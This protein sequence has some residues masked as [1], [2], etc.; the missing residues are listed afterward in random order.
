MEHYTTIAVAPAGTT[1]Q[2]LANETVFKTKPVMREFV[3]VKKVA[4]FS[5]ELVI[6]IVGDFENTVFDTES[7]TEVLAG[8][9]T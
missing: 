8:L 5:V 1:G 4:E 9:I 3:L 6:L 2:L 7:V